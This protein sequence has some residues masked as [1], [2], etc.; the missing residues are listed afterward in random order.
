MM[1]MALCPAVASAQQTLEEAT[2]SIKNILVL[3]KQG[4]AV[5]QNEVGGWYYRG[6][7][8][9]QNYEE[10]L[11]WWAK[12]AQQGNTQAIG[13]MGLCYQT[14]HGI[15]TD[16]LRASQLYLKSIK[17][18]NTALFKQHVDLAQKGNVFSNMLIASCYQNGIGVA[19][20]NNDAIPFLSNAADQ[21][22]VTA[23]RDLALLLL[24]S[25]KP[26]EAAPWFKKASDNGDVSSTFY[27]GKMLV[28]GLGI[29]AD[30]KEGA[31]YLLRAA[32]AD[33]P[34][35]MY[36]V[37]NC[38]LNGDGL[39]QSAEQAIKWY[40][41]AAGKKNVHAQWTLAQ[42]YRIGNGT[43][44]NYD[45]ALYWYAES[46]SKGYSRAFKQLMTDS[47]PDSPFATYAKG[48][49]AYYDKDYDTA[50]KYFKAVEKAKISDG[51]V[52]EA[53]ILGNSAYAKYNLKKSAKLFK[54][55]A[56]TNAQAM[57]LLGM[58]YETSTGVDQD[59][60]MS[61]EYISKSAEIGYSN[62]ECAL[63]DMYYEGRGVD[64]NYETAVA[65][66]A[67]AYE[68]GQFTENAA[69]RYA[70]CYE[71]GWGGLEINKEKAAEI[72][73]AYHKSQI[74]ELLQLI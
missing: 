58:L 19:K 55:A 74:P 42:C 4:D 20:N 15:A 23:Q 6:R 24:N 43:S 7:H 53:V 39:T 44:I 40:K 38:Y 10:A 48:V 72:R 18:G 56:K 37:G 16:S 9:T 57:Y 29:E 3:A 5:A 36:Y 26:E 34:Q 66:Y 31:N 73:K 41:L 71:N 59:M 52:M 12:S 14:G 49:K 68:Q 61:V 35:A 13:N 2:D 8:V 22:C 21:N 67:K 54:E 27:Y 11:Q 17:N 32:E 33:F 60:A 70:S 69:N 30:K 1:L 47:I 28:E 62:A 50:L 64:Q 45:Q 63:A 51:K 65:W 25:K 46:L